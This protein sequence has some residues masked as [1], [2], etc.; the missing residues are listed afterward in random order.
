MPTGENN[1]KLFFEDS[2]GN[3]VEFNGYAERKE[4]VDIMEHKKLKIMIECPEDYRDFA[5]D[6]LSDIVKTLGEEETD[7]NVEVKEM[8]LNTKI[9]VITDYVRTE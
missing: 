6:L 7:F 3:K 1:I 8:A 2:D 4:S 9:S 5:F